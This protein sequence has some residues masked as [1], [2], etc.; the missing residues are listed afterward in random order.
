MLTLP[1]LIRR[2]RTPERGH[3]LAHMLDAVWI[4]ENFHGP[5]ASAEHLQPMAVRAQ[6]IAFICNV[7]LS[8]AGSAVLRSLW[9]PAV[10]ARGSRY[11][12][13]CTYKPF[14]LYLPAAAPAGKRLVCACVGQRD[15]AANHWR[16]RSTLVDRREATTPSHRRP[17]RLAVTTKSCVLILAAAASGCCVLHFIPDFQHPQK[18]CPLVSSHRIFQESEPAM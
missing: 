17:D 1:H 6:A 18:L 12:R 15:Y 10:A 11:D 9:Q 2:C 14:A 3:R 8:A 16:T 5:S 7:R 4:L 13:C